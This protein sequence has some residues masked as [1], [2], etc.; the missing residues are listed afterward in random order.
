M[1]GDGGISW[2]SHLDETDILAFLPEALTAN[3]ETI[4][5]DQTGFVCADT[6]MM[7]F[8]LARAIH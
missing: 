2:S 3:I 1:G 8:S 7:A 4:F 6:A 5:A